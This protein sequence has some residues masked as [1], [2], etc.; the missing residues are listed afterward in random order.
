MQPI[1]IPFTDRKGYRAQVQ[2]FGLAQHAVMFFPNLKLEESDG[3]KDRFLT[4][5]STE[6]AKGL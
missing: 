5:F 3:E 6:A 2:W 1:Y 4:V